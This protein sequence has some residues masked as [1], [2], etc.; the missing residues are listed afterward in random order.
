MS[1]ESGDIPVEVVPVGDEAL[2]EVPVEEVREVDDVAAVIVGAVGGLDAEVLV[3]DE[4]AV[5]AAL[6]QLLPDDVQLAELLHSLW[7]TCV[8]Q[9]SA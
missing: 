3:Q 5:V 1:E 4:V 9:V 2:D 7:K 8:Q 6:P